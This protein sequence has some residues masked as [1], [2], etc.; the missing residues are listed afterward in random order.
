MSSDLIKCFMI[1]LTK[2]EKLR[3]DLSAMGK[4]TFFSMQL[5]A[6]YV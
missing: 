2:T 4:R 5:Q 6:L 1:T 3:N